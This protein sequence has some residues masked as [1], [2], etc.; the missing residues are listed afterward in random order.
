MQRMAI[1]IPW[2][3]CRFFPPE[4]RHFATALSDLVEAPSSFFIFIAFRGMPDRGRQFPV[5]ASAC[6]DSTTADHSVARAPGDELP[7]SGRVIS[8][9]ICA[10]G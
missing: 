8:D 4:F 10:Q 1:V 9:Q 3:G 2:T 5:D 6:S 7:T